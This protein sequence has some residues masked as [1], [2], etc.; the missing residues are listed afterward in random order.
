MSSFKGVKLT[1]PPLPSHDAAV[2]LREAVLERS[3]AFLAMIDPEDHSV[4]SYHIGTT[5]E[6]IDDRIRFGK[7]HA[8]LV[9]ILAGIASLPT[10]WP[11][12]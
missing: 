6:E 2:A 11:E 12:E 8:G 7:Y 4:T 1:T 5:K 10:H 9:R 3:G